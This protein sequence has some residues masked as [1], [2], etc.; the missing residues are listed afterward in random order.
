[1]SSNNQTDN[2]ISR[3]LNSIFYKS[4]L[5]KASRISKNSKSLLAL[6]KNA[7]NKSKDLGVGG[8]FDSIRTKVV[9]IGSLVKAYASGEYRDIELKSLIIMI[10]S[11]V[12]FISP[13]DLLPDFLPFL[14]YADDIALLTFVLQ[15]MREEVEKFEL[16]EMNKHV[17]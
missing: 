2:L 15:N 11:L 5:G 17:N 4:S 3:V 8:V 14:G 10:A 1:M 12:Y 6:L 13:I 7:L 9:T 16:W